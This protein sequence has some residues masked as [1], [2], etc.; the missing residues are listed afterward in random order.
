MKIAVTGGL[1]TGKST[2]SKILAVALQAELIDTDDLCRRH[3]QPEEEGFLE[4]QRIFG[5]T[6]LKDDG[7]IDR[8]LLRQAVFGAGGVK[9]TLENILH[10]IVRRQ[11]AAREMVATA[12]EKDLVVEVPLLFEVGWQEDFDSCVVVYVPETLCIDRVMARDAMSKDDIER[13]MG[14]QM[15]SSQKLEKADFVINNSGLF[16]STLQQTAW[17][18]RVLKGHKNS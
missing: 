10:P 9:E 3:M 18:A 12:E 6:F 13:V 14:A 16:V 5:D 8:P 2:V 15:D 11:V 4:L 7:T 1:G 17:L